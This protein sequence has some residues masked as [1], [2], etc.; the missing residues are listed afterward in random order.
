M[1]QQHAQTAAAGLQMFCKSHQI[2]TPRTNKEGDA[3]PRGFSRTPQGNVL[4]DEADILWDQH[5]L[6]L[7][8]QLSRAKGKQT[9]AERTHKSNQRDMTAC[10]YI[11]DE[12]TCLL[13][14]L[15]V[16]P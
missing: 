11:V 6:H 16:R 7:K 3:L 4:E 9:R 10:S 12:W 2:T 5:T 13:Q 15:C 8:L 14:L 1:T